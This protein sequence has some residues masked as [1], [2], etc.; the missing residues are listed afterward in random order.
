MTNA[1]AAF[2]HRRMDA[3]QAEAL[4]HDGRELVEHAAPLLPPGRRRADMSTLKRQEGSK[5]LLLRLS[6]RV[7][8]NGRKYYSRWLGL[9]K[10]VVFE[11]T[12]ADKYGNP[13]LEVFVSTPEPK[14]ETGA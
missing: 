6:E 9:S 14:S 11:A 5:V 10:V 2:V 4:A 13:Q 8:K 7:S 3:A 1:R 12:E